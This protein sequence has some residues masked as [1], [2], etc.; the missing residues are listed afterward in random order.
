MFTDQHNDYHTLSYML[1][2]VFSGKSF[3]KIRSSTIVDNVS[4][5][6]GENRLLLPKKAVR[7][8]IKGLRLVGLYGEKDYM[9]KFWKIRHKPS[10]LFIIKTIDPWKRE[11]RK[12]FPSWYKKSPS[13]FA[14]L[15]SVGKVYQTING[16]K[17]MV[18]QL[19]WIIDQFDRRNINTDE[20]FSEALEV[21]ATKDFE[22]VEF[23]VEETGVVSG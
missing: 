19:A 3:I 9:K 2:R 22:L 10:G 11:N 14:E 17:T 23:S 12:N 15:G 1:D 5:E 13:E 20:S 6:Y 16:A 21:L 18:F 7:E 8:I 4:V